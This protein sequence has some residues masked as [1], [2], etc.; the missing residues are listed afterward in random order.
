M[1]KGKGKTAAGKQESL[2]KQGEVVIN[3][4]KGFTSYHL[5]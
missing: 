4:L 5:G 3:L 1:K 2:L